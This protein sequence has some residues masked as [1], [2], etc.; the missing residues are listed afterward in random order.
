MANDIFNAE[1]D[2]IIPEGALGNQA[3]FGI[4]Y[5]DR[6]GLFR[7]LTQ[8][9]GNEVANNP[10]T[11]EFNTIGM[12]QASTEVTA[13]KVQFSK[14][15]IIEKGED[16]YEFFN[17]FNRHK[18]TGKNAKLKILLVDFM[19]SVPGK[20]EKQMYKADCLI[21]TITPDTANW[22]DAKLAMSFNQSGDRV[23]GVAEYDKVTKSAVFAPS[24]SIP[25]SGITLSEEKVTVGVG[26]EKWVSVDFEPFGAPDAF[27]QVSS[28]PGVCT[29]EARRQSV[30]ITGIKTGSATVTVKDAATEIVTKAID[31]TVGEIESNPDEEEL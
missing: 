21:C 7:R 5:Q 17:D 22:T 26:K 3:Y 29:A 15:V 6:L 28:N 18:F 27:V 25:I 4:F 23:S 8:A 9:E 20:N 19:E 13:F 12:K 16:N 31:V 14:D 10:E 1:F 24:S 11:K 30:V 2:E